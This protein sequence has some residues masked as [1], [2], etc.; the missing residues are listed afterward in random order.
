MTGNVFYDNGGQSFQNAQLFLAGKSGGRLVKNWQTGASTNVYTKNLKLENNVI[1]GVGSNQYVFSTYLGGTDWS[2]F[3]YSLTSNNN[4]WYDSAKTSAFSV[5]GGHS[6]T[7]SGWRSLSRQDSSSVWASAPSSCGVPSPAYPDFQLL[8]HNAASY[9][10]GYTMSKGTLSIPLQIRS[11]RYG[12]VRLSVTGLPSGVSGSF[13]ASSLVSGNSTLTLRATS[14][15]AYETVP[16]TIVGVSGSRVHTL[17]V[18]VA[19]RPA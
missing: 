5:A 6:T 11:F 10:S 4:H 9:V 19:V 7:L 18:K 12:T 1:I 16:V 15:A 3:I 13:S 14:S 17:T 2:N 8:G